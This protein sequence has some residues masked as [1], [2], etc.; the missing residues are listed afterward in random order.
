MTAEKLIHL[1][2]ASL[3]LSDSFK[4]M[5]SRQSFQTLADIL[6]WP[7][8]ILLQHDGFTQHHYQELRTFLSANNL[9]HLLKADL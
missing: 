7:A 5:A 1:P 4:R 9:I 2:I 8:S 6:N 3:S